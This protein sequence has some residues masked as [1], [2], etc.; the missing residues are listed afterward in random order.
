FIILN[1]VHSC[2]GGRPHGRSLGVSASERAFTYGRRP[3]PR[4]RRQRRRPA[5]AEERG[6]TARR[7][8]GRRDPVRGSLAE[9]PS[10]GRRRAARDAALLLGDRAAR[11]RPLPRFALELLRLATT[12]AGPN[13]CGSGRGGA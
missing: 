4:A 1:D 12:A 3:T 8:A 13:R 6:R 9:R 5:G 10:L 2:D 11:V 7:A